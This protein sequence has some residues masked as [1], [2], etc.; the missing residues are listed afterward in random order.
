MKRNSLLVAV[1]LGLLACPLAGQDAVGLYQQACDDGGMLECDLLGVMYRDGIG[2]TQNLAL[3]ASLFR[4]AC[5][6]E[7]MQGCSRLGVMYANGVGVTQDIARG[8][9]LFQRA[10]DGADQQGCDN[11]EA[12]LELMSIALRDAGAEP[13]E[14]GNVTAVPLV[15]GDE[16]ETDDLARLCQDLSSGQHPQLGRQPLQELEQRYAQLKAQI[17]GGTGAANVVLAEAAILLAEERVSHGEFEGTFE[18]YEEVRSLVAGLD[19]VPRGLEQVDFLEA[20]AHLRAGDD[21]NCIHGDNPCLL[22]HG[23]DG[24]YSD[25]AHPLAATEL[26][27][28]DLGRHP[29][30]LVSRWLL[31]LA[32]AIIGRHPEGVPEQWL[33]DLAAFSADKPVPRLLDV[34]RP[35]GLAPSNAAGGVVMD[36]FDGDGLLDIFITSVEPCSHAVLYRNQG[37]GTFVDRSIEAGLLDQLGG[38]NVQQT[39]YDNDGDLDLFITRGGWQQDFGRQRNS[40]LRN[41]GDGRFTDVTHAAGLAEP[42]LPTQASAWADYDNDGDL[43]L[44][45]GNEVS[46]RSEAFHSQLFRNE[47]N[48][49]FVDVAVAAGVTNQR[50]AKGVSWGDY[51][52]DGDPD[53]YVSNIGLNRLYRNEGNGRFVDVAI[54]LGVAGPPNGRSFATWFWDYD[55]DGALDLFVA[56]Y[57]GAPE[58]AMADLLGR[59]DSPRGEMQ[60]RLYRNDGQGGFEDVSREAGVFHVRL[61]MGANFGDIDND[62]WPDFYLGTGNP[63]LWAL[64]PNV[65]Y[66]NERG[67]RFHDVTLSAGVGHLPKGHGVAFGDID[68]DG[69]QDMYLRA[70]GFVPAD[71]ARNALFENPGAGNHWLTVRLL[72]RTVNRPAIMGRIRVDII[73][74]GEPRTVYAL[75]SSGGSFGANSLQQE[76]GLGQAERI[77]G[78][79]VWWPGEPTWQDYPAVDLDIQIEIEQGELEPRVIERAAFELRR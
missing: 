20:L 73:E 56:G 45:I 9:S 60:S 72:G 53:L 13:I 36:D 64:L 58:D 6:G 33:L 79:A 68:N 5:D 7:M 49:R 44:Y 21:A 35:L 22:F 24:I 14:P 16:G 59:L 12:L 63:S 37:D 41:D 15:T 11:L 10:C 78:L 17:T 8:L 19:N 55:N 65:M 43:D 46:D 28:R 77:E 69:D 74:D 57:G 27:Q 66:W 47:G 62:G 25:Q 26:L 61:P 48:G 30:D 42:A 70:G 54:E 4:Q 76:I 75:V 31:N 1:F 71:V 51:D 34:A 32:Y 38:L 18:L 52:N 3:A 50:M 2:V 40:L 23:P 67:E 29:D 39:D